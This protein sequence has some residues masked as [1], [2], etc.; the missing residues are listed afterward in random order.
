MGPSRHGAHIQQSHK[1]SVPPLPSLKFPGTLTIFP[2][3]AQVGGEEKAKSSSEAV[4]KGLTLLSISKGFPP[5]DSTNKYL[6]YL[7]YT[8]FYI[9][10]ADTTISALWNPWPN[11]HSHIACLL[12][13]EGG[14]LPHWCH[15]NILSFSYSREECATTKAP[16]GSL[17]W[18]LHFVSRA[19]LTHKTMRDLYSTLLLRSPLVQKHLLPDLRELSDTL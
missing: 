8:E 17:V 16:S 18:T 15:D 13:G 11:S 19:H 4:S 9:L 1:H 5:L 10:K 6:M 7:V 3:A 12:A 2:E 14:L